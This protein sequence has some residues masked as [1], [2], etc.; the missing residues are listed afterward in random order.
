MNVSNL[1]SLGLFSTFMF[2]VFEPMTRQYDKRVLTQR[3]NKFDPI[4]E[5]F[6]HYLELD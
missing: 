4:R 1:A 6:T 3:E 5:I 2:A